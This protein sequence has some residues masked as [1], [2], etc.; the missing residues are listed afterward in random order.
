MVLIY[1]KIKCANLPKTLNELRYSMAIT[2]DKPSKKLPP[3]DDAFAQ[4]VKRC[5]FQTFIWISSDQG[6]PNIADPNG[7]GWRLV[8]GKLDIIY[9]EREPVPEN[10]RKII[11]YFCTDN[12]Q[13]NK[14]RCKKQKLRCT[15]ICKCKGR[16]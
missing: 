9:T 8:N 15:E 10:F 14:C 11:N 12:C 3:T 13:T 2:S 5:R 7:N 16:C 6:M 1:P 4:H